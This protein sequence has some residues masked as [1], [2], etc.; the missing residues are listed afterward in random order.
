MPPRNA[1]E[2]FANE[3]REWHYLTAGLAV[4][5]LLGYVLADVLHRTLGGGGRR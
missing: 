5:A 3:W 2:E 1:L 4:G